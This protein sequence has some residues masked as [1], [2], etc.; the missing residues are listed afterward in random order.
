MSSF[1]TPHSCFGWCAK[2]QTEHRLEQGDARRHA[3]LLMQQLQEFKRIDFCRPSANSDPRFSTDYL[4]GL[5]LGQMFGVLE[6]MDGAGEI[7]VLRAFS[8]Q[9]NGV[10]KVD[11]WVPPLFDME[12]FDRIMIPGDREIKKLGT[13]IEA[14]DVGDEERA[15]LKNQRKHLSRSIMKD[16]HDLYQLPN[17]HGET[18]PL[19]EFFKHVNGPPTG[20]GDCCGP[21]LLNFAARKQLQPLGIAEFYWG[22]NNRS[23]TCEHGRFYSSCEDKCLPIL[24]FMLCGGG[25]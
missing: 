24:G 21:K 13:K 4:F 20:A 9:Y 12:A 16:L 11:G 7:V 3:M 6:C 18:M 22:K 19:K 10:W 1:I 14:L 17:F 8:G 2:C 25:S 5:A 23:G 15:H